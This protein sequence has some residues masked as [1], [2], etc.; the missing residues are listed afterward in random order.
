MK[1]EPKSITRINSSMHA[2]ALRT[3][4]AELNCVPLP[5][6]ETTDEEAETYFNWYELNRQIAE[7]N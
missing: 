2:D 4:I 5:N 6:L 7:W 1:K 3:E